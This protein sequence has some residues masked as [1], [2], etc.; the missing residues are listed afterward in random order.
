[1]KNLQK[2]ACKNPIF[3]LIPHEEEK[4]NAF[5]RKDGVMTYFR[6]PGPYP[7]TALHVFTKATKCVQMTST[8][9]CW[10]PYHQLAKAI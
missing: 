7:T 6:I 1:L 2:N 3:D 5:F 4:W 9:K 10:Y 8:H